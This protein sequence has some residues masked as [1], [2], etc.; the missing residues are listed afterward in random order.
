MSITKVGWAQCLI[1]VRFNRSLDAWVRF[2]TWARNFKLFG[3]SFEFCQWEDLHS[4]E[5]REVEFTTLTTNL[6]FCDYLFESQSRLQ[7]LIR[8]QKNPGLSALESQLRH[9]GILTKSPKLMS[10]VG[11]DA[12]SY[13]MSSEDCH[14][15]NNKRWY[16]E[17]GAY[18]TWMVWSGLRS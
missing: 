14:K 18:R 6:L 4:R 2:P 8:R 15:Y 11:L 12:L 3:A 9:L 7:I 17:F 1:H 10:R 5:W 13:R 16:S